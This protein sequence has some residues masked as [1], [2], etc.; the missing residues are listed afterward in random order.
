[1]EA[2]DSFVE[3]VSSF[4]LYM[5]SRDGTWVTRLS[6]KCFQP[7]SH[8]TGPGFAV[9]FNFLLKGSFSVS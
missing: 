9:F 2:E 1:M 3:S 4:H 8:L 5:S 6:G 7:P